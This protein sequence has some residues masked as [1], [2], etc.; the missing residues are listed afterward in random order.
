MMSAKLSHVLD[1]LSKHYQPFTL[2]SQERLRE[3][4]SIVRF[5]EMR[6]GEIFQITGGTDQDYLFVVEGRLEVIYSGAVKSIAGPDDTSKRPVL[7]P[8]APATSTLVARED[9][10]ICH[11]DRE[12]LDKLISW[13]EVVHMMEDTGEDTA[14]LLERVRNSLVFRRL[15]LEMVESAFKKM[16][17]EQVKAGQ[18]VIKQGDEGD[19]YY[20]IVSGTAEVYQI[21]LY[22]DEPQKIADIREG[23]AFGCEALIS[24]STRNE[25]VLMKED[26]EVLV[27]DKAAFEELISNPLIKTVHPSVAKTMLETGYELIDV[28]YS[29]EYDEHHIPGATLIPLYELRNRMDELDAGKKYIV[30]CH[31]GSR[32][33]VATLV[34]AQ[35]QFDVLSLEGG[36]RSWPFE[37]ASIYD[38]K[39]VT[40]G[41]EAA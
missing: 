5:V 39:L 8:A 21:G 33:A 6:E 40:G 36:I 19:A 29:E 34:L 37:T 2:L 17:C 18:Y 1:R 24:G 41:D 11:A 32:S 4:V 10:I 30:Y 28:R 38:K 26:G 3:V 7:L 9:S 15:P 27:L 25:S 13:D 23:D 31:G 22:D 35:N 16:R 12:M 20:I 14:K